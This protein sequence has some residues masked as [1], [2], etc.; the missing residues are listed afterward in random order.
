MW[1][2]LA[3][4]LDEEQLAMKDHRQSVAGQTLT[5]LYEEFKDIKGYSESVTRRRTDITI[6]KRK[7]TKRQTTIYKTLHTKLIYVIFYL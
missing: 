4:I 2:K 6:V 7:G 5:T 3:G 1:R